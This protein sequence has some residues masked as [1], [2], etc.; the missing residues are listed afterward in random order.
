[1]ARGCI[2]RVCLS[3]A[4]GAVSAPRPAMTAKRLRRRSYTISATSATRKDVRGFHASACGI[5]YV[6]TY[7]AFS[8]PGKTPELNEFR[9]GTSANGST[10]RPITVSWSSISLSLAGR[11][12]TRIRDCNAWRS[13]LLRPIVRRPKTTDSSSQPQAEA[14]LPVEMELSRR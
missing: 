7:V 14:D 8:R 3:V 9:C 1:M 12:G 4:A 5:Q 2:R 6:L 11:S 10:F 13:V